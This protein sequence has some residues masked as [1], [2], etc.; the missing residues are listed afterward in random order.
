MISGKTELTKYF[1][2]TDQDTL[3]ILT[4]EF[5]KRQPITITNQARWSETLK[6]ESGGTFQLWH[7]KI[8]FIIPRYE[9]L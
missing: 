2:A 1:K 6:T 4:N 3:T 9:I 5:I 7:Q 8:T